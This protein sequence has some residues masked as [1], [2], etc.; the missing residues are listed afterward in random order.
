[1]FDHTCLL[2]HERRTVRFGCIAASPSIVEEEEVP[3]PA[4]EGARS[5]A[6]PSVMDLSVS[7]WPARADRLVLVDRRAGL[8]VRAA[9]PA[10][11][12]VGG[13]VLSLATAP[14]VLGAL[15]VA[16]C[17]LGRGVLLRQPR[18]GQGGRVFGMY[19]IRTMRPDRRLRQLPYDGPERR[20]LHK[21]ADDPRHTTFGR[22]LRKWSI[23][24]LPQLWNV[25]LGD[26]SL[27]GPR[28]EL[29]SVVDHYELWDH[30]RHFVRPGVTGLWQV[31]DLRAAP[32][33]ESVHI[34]L[35]YLRNV[36]FASDARILLGTMQALRDGNGS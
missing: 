23:D 28:P 18:V 22:F 25:V 36:T 5:P 29:A 10:L 2:E 7:P 17:L 31:S 16:R 24:E 26:M 1:L 21:R 32:L 9:K 30:P 4:V 20:T 35:E 27:V 8:Y 33:H 13:L 14:V 6:R 12:L 15:V 19:K 34:D 11:D 3:A